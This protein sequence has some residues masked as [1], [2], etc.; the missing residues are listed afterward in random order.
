MLGFCALAPLGDAV[1]KL[2]GETIPLGQMLL[3][4]F[5]V[6][7]V[8]LVPFVLWA[9]RAWRMSP[10]ILGLTALRTVLHILGIG[11][12]FTALQYLP[13]AD[14]V[15]IAFVMPFILLLLGKLCLNEQVGHRRL[16]A[17]V[18]GFL[19]T[20]LVIKPSFAEVGL[21]AL[22]PLAVAV[23]F[24]VFMLITRQISRDTD[25]IGLQAVS[26][27]MAMILILPAVAL[28]H[29]AAVPI[30]TLVP[31]NGFETLLLATIGILGTFAHLLMTW[32]LRYAPSA[33]LAS[34]FKQK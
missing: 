29:G 6:Q 14:A 15:A 27:V 1:A 23:V 30:L 19:G 25:P 34:I 31:A 26:G 7:A 10:R 20:L 9:G 18:I 4:R 3:V 32:A 28:G 24:S 11:A 17:C 13:L 21:P 2:L 16:M 33:T 12:M 22:L 5:G 8:V